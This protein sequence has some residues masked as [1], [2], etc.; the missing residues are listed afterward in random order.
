M[1]ED[2]KDAKLQGL[3]H[4][5]PMKMVMARETNDLV[6]YKEF[7]DFHA[8]CQSCKHNDS[9]HQPIASKAELE[10]KKYD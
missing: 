9:N 8:F 3:N 5:F 7:G 4:L 1:L 2:P 6:Y 10:Q